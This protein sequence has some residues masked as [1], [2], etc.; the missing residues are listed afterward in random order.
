VNR[1][2]E[3]HEHASGKSVNVARV[4]TTLGEAALAAGF[5]G[6]RRG[7]ALLQDMTQAG[8]KHDFVKIKNQTRLCTTL[9]DRASG[10]ATELV[11]EAPAASLEEWKAM[12]VKIETH[13]D[14]ADAIVFSG[15]LAA[16]APVSF[17]HRWIGRAPLTVVDAKGEAMRRVLQSRG[18]VIAKL[19]R[20]E[21]CETMGERLERDGDLYRAMKRC[22]PM[23]G[24][25]IVTLG[26]AGAIAAVGA[27]LIRVHAP[28]VAAVSAVGSGD[29]FTAGLVAGMKLGTEGALKLACACGSANALTAFSGQL[30]REDVER[31]VPQVRLERIGGVNA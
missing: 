10:E 30:V 31:L 16:G 6:G 26:K 22:K 9:I 24:R 7:E 25:L 4:L 29:A 14:G 13:V 27:E 18:N 17:C 5:A 12:M 11:E 21:F 20:Q 15:T 3:V 8:I 1:A 19:N 23:D 28:E 2:I